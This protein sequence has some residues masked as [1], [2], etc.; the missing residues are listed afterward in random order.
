MPQTNLISQ[1]AISSS[2]GVSRKHVAEF[3]EVADCDLK[4]DYA[5]LF[6]TSSRFSSWFT[7]MVH[8][9][10]SDGSS[11]GSG[12]DSPNAISYFASSGAAL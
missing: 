11:F 6:S 5:H 10:S 2:Q 3:N 12:F 9:A 7:S 4:A 1:I 8:P